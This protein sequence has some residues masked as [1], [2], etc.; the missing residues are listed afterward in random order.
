MIAV[1]LISH[2]DFAASLKKASE[3]VYGPQEALAAIGLYGDAGLESLAAEI[4]AQ[5]DAFAAEGYQVICLTDLPHATPYNAALIALDGT[6][7]RIVS[8]MNLPML[9]QILSERED[10]E[11]DGIDEFLESAAETAKESI[12]VCSTVSADEEEEEDDF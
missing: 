10:V 9:V 6:D 3:M 7:S 12:E 5:Y 4:R 11:P 8:G 2:S 1:I